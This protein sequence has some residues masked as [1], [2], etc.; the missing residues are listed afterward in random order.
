MKL[1]YRIPY[2]PYKIK[3]DLLLSTEPKLEIPRALRP[4]H[5]I[6][7]N[8]LDVAPLYFVLYHKLLG[9]DDRVDSP[10]YW[11][12]VKA[13]QVDYP[14]ILSL[15]AIAKSEGLRPLS[16]SHMGRLYLDNFRARADAFVEQYGHS[17]RTRFQWLGFLV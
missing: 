10:E 17:A 15:C 12:R 5:F 13:A 4:I 14:D 7:L 1:F 16:K 9:W 8:Q 6:Y 3:V 2:T 11:K